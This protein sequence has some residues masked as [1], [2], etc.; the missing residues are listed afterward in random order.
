M[1][2]THASSPTI[3]PQ[4]PRPTRTTEGDEGTLS[5]QLAALPRRSDVHGSAPATPA[6]SPTDSDETPSES[7]TRHKSFRGDIQA[8]RAFAVMAV[9][10]NHLWA[11]R[12]TGGFIGVDIFFVIS[13]FLI[14]THLMKDTLHGK[15]V[16]LLHF[17]ARRIR[18]LLPAAFL[19]LALSFVGVMAF[20]PVYHWKHNFTEILAAAGYSENI[21]LTV[22]A[23]DYHAIGQQATVAQHYW[24][25]SV[26]EQFYFL[27]PMLLMAVGMFAARRGKNPVR[28]TAWTIGI[29][30]VSFLAF[31]VWFTAY[32]PAQAYF[33][34]PVRFWE[35]GIGGL[36][37]LAARSLHEAREPRSAATLAG[38]L[39]SRSQARK[40]SARRRYLRAFVALLAWIVLACSA[41]FYSAH[42]PFP[43]ATALVPVLATAIIIL[44]GTGTPL[45]I[46]D[47]LTSF[48]VIRWIGDIS[49][50]LYLWHWPLIVIAPYALGR[51]TNWR[52]KLVLLALT[53]VLAG[54]S[55]PLVE[56]KGLEWSWLA[57]SLKRTFMTMLVAVA[58]FAGMTVGGHVHAQTLIDEER[59]RVV[60][61]QER[62]A[63]EFQANMA[64]G[65][66][67][68][69]DCF[70]PGAL[71]NPADCRNVFDKP[72]STTIGDAENY[73]AMPSDCRLDDS[74]KGEKF[75]GIQVCDFRE[76][77]AA[78][79][80]EKTILLVGDSHADQWKWPLYEIA[81][82]H[83]LRLEAMIIG[84]CPVRFLATEEDEAGQ[85]KNFG[86]E[87][88]EA[89][90]I[91]NKY[92]AAHTPQRIVQS[93][94][95]KSQPL[96]EKG[97]LTDQNALYAD[98]F[99]KL[100][101]HWRSLGVKDITVIADVPYNDQVRDLACTALTE[102]PAIDCRVDR[103]KALGEDYLFNVVRDKSFAGVKGVD[104]TNAFCDD[105]FCYAVAGQMLVYFD[106]THVNRQYV[107]KLVPQ[108]EAELGY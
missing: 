82:K 43:S 108:L 62:L 41:Y 14:S 5:Q 63:A 3:P 67:K 20:M 52:D 99:P 50:S 28:A 59:A 96:P 18:R 32:S 79:S 16:R 17:Y 57:S 65:A 48:P 11:H 90:Q 74:Y 76:N 98:A 36:T 68:N 104:F 29:F 83:K 91:I 22:Q 34:T 66:K 54:L 94:Y 77:T 61:E 25:L 88:T 58:T 89:T 53:F 15:K 86:A 81:K 101:E 33:V 95:A 40:S 73:Y 107:L 102:N 103:V 35:F 27:W 9:I 19:V 70:G 69:I 55:K 2:H 45:P 60:A 80:R 85:T 1:T 4:G 10:V 64:D 23:V 56:D 6:D 24:S 39:P 75:A 38:R 106:T 49:Y 78:A 47:R 12:L 46:L 84:G 51:M 13:G 8:L 31:S 92:I 87:C 97:S 71:Q 42:I 26:E 93:Q 30:T 100:W 44:T 7:R 21:Y 72:L 105:T 37:A